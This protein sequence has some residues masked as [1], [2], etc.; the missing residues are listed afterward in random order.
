[1]CT[2]DSVMGGA[3]KN[4]FFKNNGKNEWLNGFE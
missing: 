1:M 2:C 4:T 3:K